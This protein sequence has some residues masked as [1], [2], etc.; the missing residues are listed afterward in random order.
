MWH[1]ETLS[2]TNKVINKLL[3]P[4][5][6]VKFESGFSGILWGR[7]QRAESHLKTKRKNGDFNKEE[8]IERYQTGYS[9]SLTTKFVIL[10]LDEKSER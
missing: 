10:Y 6:K 5:S 4:A 9:G 1:L 7:Q 3:V 8:H 2:E